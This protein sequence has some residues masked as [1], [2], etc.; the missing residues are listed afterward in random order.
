MSKLSDL[1]RRVPALLLVEVFVLGNLAFLA[2]DVYLAHSI[3]AFGRRVEWIPIGVS[4][5]GPVFLLAALRWR[6]DVVPGQTRRG[7]GLLLGWV[8]I[9]V[10]IAGMLFHLED[11][12]FQQAS[13]KN[14]VYIAPF[15]APL[16]YAGLGFLILLNRQVDPSSTEWS[17]W[18]IFL[19]LGGFV[20]N[21][22]LTLCD[23]AQN[24][25]F[26]MGEWIPVFASAVVV[27]FLTV[28]LLGRPT[29]AFLGWCA[30]ILLVQIA[31]GV[32]GLAYHVQAI[33]ATPGSGWWIKIL[34]GAP[35]FAPLLFADLAVLGLIGLWDLAGKLSPTEMKELP[36]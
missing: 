31:V 12:F 10:G 16:A 19:C 5:V 29:R 26:S 33:L 1:L 35:L 7:I 15:A 11:T 14:L 21:F 8:C 2:L 28:A 3:N 23:H 17:Q 4:L 22:A 30:V 24:G 32:L 20:G 36:S 6:S 18:V 34:Y 25:F 9:G 27:G 13:L